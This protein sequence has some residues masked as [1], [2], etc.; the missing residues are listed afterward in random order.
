MSRAPH[1]IRFL[2]LAVEDLINELKNDHTPPSAD[3]TTCCKRDRR[4]P[5]VQLEDLTVTRT[6]SNLQK[7]EHEVQRPGGASAGR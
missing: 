5:P 4:R 2:T 3:H 6:I 1:S 7:Y